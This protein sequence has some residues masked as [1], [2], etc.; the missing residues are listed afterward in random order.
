MTTLATTRRSPRAQQILTAT[1]M[2]AALYASMGWRVY[3]P[4]TTA[5][6]V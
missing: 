3:C 5:A 2:G 1:D 4:Y 6:I